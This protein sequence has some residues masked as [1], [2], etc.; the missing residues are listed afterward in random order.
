MSC[1]FRVNTLKVPLPT[2]PNPQIPTFTAFKV[3]SPT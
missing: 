3:V 1:A 2:V